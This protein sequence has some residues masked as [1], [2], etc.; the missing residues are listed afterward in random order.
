MT[1]YCRMSRRILSIA[2][3]LLVLA[4]VA[5]VASSEQVLIRETEYVVEQ[6][7]TPI[8]YE[9]YLKYETPEGYLYTNEAMVYVTLLDGSQDKTTYAYEVYVDKEYNPKSQIQISES[10]GVVTTVETQF[11][12]HE[13]GIKAIATTT[14]SGREYTQEAEVSAR[15]FCPSEALLDYLAESGL[16]KPG[17]KDEIYTWSAEQ[18]IFD[19]THIEV[20]GETTFD[21]QGQEMP[22]YLV[23][24]S[25]QGVPLQL[26]VSPDGTPYKYEIPLIGVQ[27]RLTDPDEKIG[28]FSPMILDMVGGRGNIVVSHPLRSVNSRITISFDGLP[29]G[30]ASF[31]DNRQRVVS[32]SINEDG[33]SEVVVEISV[34]TTDRT[35]WASLPVTDEG[36]EEYLGTTRHITPDYEPIKEAA[37]EVIGDETDVYR[38]VE[39]L[40]A[41]TH[42][43]LDYNITL[44]IFSAPDIFELRQGRCTEFSILFASLT[45]AVGI[46]S[47]LALGFR[48]DG[49]TWVGHMWNEVYIGEWVAVDAT[50]G[51]MAPD[52]LVVKV[53]HAS[54]LTGDESLTTTVFTGHRFYIDSVTLK[55][56][57]A[58]EGVPAQ[59]GIY[60]NQYTSLEYACQ[61]SVPENWAM[62]EVTQA[63]EWML[64]MQHQAGGASAILMTLEAPIGMKAD[65]VLLASIQ[66]AAATMPVEVIS[67][68]SI[69]LGN[70]TGSTARLRIDADGN[71]V[72]QDAIVAVSEDIV[73]VV[74]LSA[75]EAM[76]D[77]FAADF[78]QIKDSF[79]SWR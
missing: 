37:L 19:L 55:E 42:N 64:V 23:S 65:D 58:P 45:R 43:Y 79:I 27:S 15:A 57:E 11:E 13:E 8:G 62:F 66:Q 33:V 31:T 34:D 38:A 36:L 24:I 26:V 73:Y 29:I 18:E 12:Q 7:G 77:S 46:P 22:A 52:A 53:A 21:Y 2:V 47:R 54:S 3:T 68:G 59:S 4:T 63:G 32:E 20:L 25:E 41:F 48:Y 56:I 61:I 69:P 60:E 72:L 9:R 70:L 17:Y 75:L 49:T 14:V 5:A 1:K 44:E 39:K 74:T 16:L 50:Q 71:S 6:Q 28:K 76:W 30:A 40:L 78:D 10:S 51:Q 67:S 35:G